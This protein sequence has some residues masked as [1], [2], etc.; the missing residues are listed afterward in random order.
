MDEGVSKTGDEVPRNISPQQ[1][2]KESCRVKVKAAAQASNKSCCFNFQPQDKS[3]AVVWK[4]AGN[5]T[6]NEG[7]RKREGGFIPLD[8][9]I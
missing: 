2:R 1:R 4:R 5:S 3:S 8:L 6:G 7:E 9:H